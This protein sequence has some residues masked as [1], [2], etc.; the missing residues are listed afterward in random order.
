MAFDDHQ[1][2]ILGIATSYRNYTT[3]QYMEF[4]LWHSVLW[5]HVVSDVEQFDS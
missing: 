3:G 4:S 1:K 5:I 2:H